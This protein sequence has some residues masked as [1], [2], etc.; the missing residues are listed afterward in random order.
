MGLG[1]VWLALL[2]SLPAIAEAKLPARCI[3]AIGA[4]TRTFGDLV[5]DQL[6]E[7][8]GTRGISLAHDAAALASYLKCPTDAVVK[9]VDCIVAFVHST[10]KRPEVTDVVG[11]VEE[12]PGRPCSSDVRE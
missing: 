8:D 3:H 11:C 7:L 10:N 6:I 5:S 4:I 9:S 12:A 1:C 2:V